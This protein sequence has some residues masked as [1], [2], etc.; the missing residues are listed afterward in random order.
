[1]STKKLSITLVVF[2]LLSNDIAANEAYNVVKVWPEAPQG[3]HFY[4]PQGVA[5]DQSGNVYIGDSGNYCVKKFDSEGRFITQWGSPGQGNG[6]FSKIQGVKVGS[7][8]TVYVVDE[9]D[10]TGITKSRIQKFN[11]YGQ[12]IGLLER[13]APGANKV[14]L[15]VDVTED[16]K[17]NIFVLAVDFLKKEG[18]V[19]LTGIEKYS[20]NGDFIAE[21][22]IDAGSGDGQ[23][24][25]PTAIAID[26]N[27]NIYIVEYANER[28]QKFDSSGN[29]LMKWGTPGKGEGHFSR[30]NCIAIDKSGKVYVLDASYVQKFTPE[31]Q[32]LA[33]WKAKSRP[34]GIALDSQS[35]VY[36]TC[37]GSHSVQKFDNSGKEI[38][39]WVNTASEDN[40]LISPKS[41]ALDSSSNIFVADTKNNRIQRFDSEV[42]F[43]SNLGGELWPGVASLATDASGNL[44]VA[45]WE[46]DEVQKYNPDGKLIGRWGSTGNG[47]G[48]F[49]Y[50]PAIAVGPSGNV[51]MAD[52]GNCR[53]QKFTS[54]GEFLAK[55][56]TKGAGDGQFDNP[57]FISVDGSGNV[58]VGDQLSNG[59]H[60][61]Q[62]FDADG[63]FLT[64]WT[65]RIMTPRG[66]RLTGAVA[67]DS[68]GNSFYA[69]ETRIEKY[70]AKGNPVSRYGQEEFTKDKLEKVRG[71]CVDK[72]GCLYISC[73]ADP[74]IHVVNTTGSIRKYDPD[75]KLVS[76]WTTEST[77]GKEKLPNGPI[78]VDGDENVYVS[79]LAGVPVCK[80]SPDGKFVAEFQIEPPLRGGGFS[81]L[82]GVA[83]DSSGMVYAVDS[84]DVDWDY[85]IPSIKKFD[86]NGEFI[87]LWGAPEDAEGKFKYPA[88]IAVDDSGY[89]YVTD[90]TSHCVHKFDVR[91]T[92]VKSWGSKGIGDGQF[93]TPEGIVVDKSGNVLVCDRQNCRIQKFNSDGKF[94]TKWGREGSGDGEFHFPAAVAVDKRSNVFVADSDNH[95]V[96]KFTTEGK[97]LTKWGEF[98]EGPGQFSV[99]LGI[100]V[101]EAGNVFV[102]D[103]HNHR[104]QKFAPM[105]SR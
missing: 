48:Q 69:F 77:E 72:E 19:L 96:Q 85:G 63:R 80:L 38:S 93:D 90:K 46:P 47:D 31:G 64:K 60:R 71:M 13:K 82:G 87:T 84:V 35:N 43:L 34:S 9:D 51:Y 16:D 73:P 76:K 102:S 103:S 58:W 7:S 36:V 55:W 81:L 32:F 62:K 2:G 99:P 11:S 12:F 67:I 78:T 56:G 6:Q 74:L 10:R 100:A 52:S 68:S 44:Y 30:P 91:G 15:S 89:A 101:D 41:I 5:V 25:I 50:V 49:S 33:R 105:P 18:R 92:Y 94:L 79:Y 1:M 27:G 53:V 61:M 39:K 98:G 37:M 54:E 26:T 14:D 88:L 40:Q 29:F 8:G 104:I 95:R 42:N 20:M 70:D 45:C 3:W 86:S 24:Q 97:F 57:F 66:M 21:W 65:K 83:V 59:T 17:G 23:L 22:G 28:V 75:G 4:Q